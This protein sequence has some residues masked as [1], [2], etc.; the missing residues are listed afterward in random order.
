MRN[1]CCYCGDPATTRDHVP[2]KKLFP[3]PRPTDLITVPSCGPCNTRLSAEEEYFIHVLISIR[4]AVTPV[5]H[6]LRE[7]R[8]S[9]DP[10][11]RHVRMAHR[12]L[13]SMHA[14]DV[15]TPGGL[16]LGT[17]TAFTIDRER[18]D[19][20]A[21]KIT[22]GLYFAEFAQRVPLDCAAHVLLTPPRQV[23]ESPDVIRVIDEGRGRAIGG[24]A[25]AYRIAHALEVPCLVFC[26]MLFFEAI[27]VICSF[28]PAT[29]S[30]GEVS[31]GS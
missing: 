10:T 24:Q 25:F 23:L 26:L 14:K 21:E 15:L 8:F 2:T 6:Q 30:G 13:S 1:Q 16:Y 7:Q 5:V 3:A 12:M 19:R 22:R 18:F 20:V 4:G 11:P 31:S 29:P 27:P 9:R 28:Q 17:A